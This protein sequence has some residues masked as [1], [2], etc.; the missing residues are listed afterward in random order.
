LLNKSVK[1]EHFTES[2]IRSPE[3]AAFIKRIKLEKSDDVEFE[4]ARLKLIMKDGRELIESQEIAR[5][6]P[7]NPISK[8]DILAK[9]WTNVEFS[10]KITREKA[11]E[12]L[13][14]VENLEEL[15][16]VRRLIPLLVA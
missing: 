1:P 6:D 14:T 4:S 16:S 9:F 11:T 3:T 15:D 10:G 12:F 13:K 5:G 2:A 7:L 8:D